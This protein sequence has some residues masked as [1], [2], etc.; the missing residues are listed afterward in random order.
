MILP[1]KVEGK[2]FIVTLLICLFASLVTS[3]YIL[4]TEQNRLVAET[5]ERLET[6][7]MR[8]VGHIM[9][10]LK[11]REN[12][13]K[14]AAKSIEAA[15]TS[16]PDQQ[17]FSLRSNPDGSITGIS[18]TLASSYYLPAGTELT[19]DLNS[20]ILGTQKAID[21]LAP[22][23]LS[24]FSKVTLITTDNIII[25]APPSL[26]P[27]GFDPES[28]PLMREA[29]TQYQSFWT[30]VRYD[31]DSRTWLTSLVVPLRHAGRYL[32]MLRC[33][34]KLDRIFS[35]IGSLAGIEG[36]SAFI[37]Q[38]TDT[39]LAHN[40]IASLIQ[41]NKGV[42]NDISASDIN[43]PN[44]H[45]IVQIYN[46]SLNHNTKSTQA[47]PVFTY[48]HD[49][50]EYYAF[51]HATALSAW[52]WKL[53]VYTD[54]S[55]I[56]TYV[57][58]LAW[59]SLFSSMALAF[60]FML[61][62]RD[63]FRRLFLKRIIALEKATHDYADTEEFI[64]PNSGKD[65]IGQLAFSF[66]NLIH[67]L[68]AGKVRLTEQAL[69]L[70]SEILERQT[71]VESLEESEDKFEALFEN[72]PDAIMLLDDKTCIDCNLAAVDLLEFPDKSQLLQNTIADSSPTFQPDGQASAEK[73]ETLVKHAH[74]YGKYNFE[75]VIKTVSDETIWVDVLLT[76]IPYQ[77]TKILYA[78]MRNISDRKREEVERVRLT[79]AIEQAAESIMVTD[80]SG[81]ILYVNPAFQELNQY[82]REEIIGKN[83]EILYGDNPKSV[84]I[85]DILSSVFR[86]IIWKGRLTYRRNDQ[87]EYQA[88]STISPVRDTGG[89]IMNFVYVS[90]DVTKEASLET[91]LRQAQKMEAIGELASGIAHEINTPTQYIG[92][93]IRFFRD[94]FQDITD[95]LNKFKKL[96]ANSENGSTL[97]KDRADI[98]KLIDDIDLEF[99]EEEI[100]TAIEQ[101]LDGNKRVAEIVRAMKEFAHPGTEERSA[102]DVNHAIRNTMSVARNEWKYVAEIETDLAEDLPLVPC[103]PGS[104]NQVILNL[105]VNAA[106]AIGDV[107]KDGSGGKGTIKVST[108]DD[109]GWVE[110]RISDTGCGIPESNRTKIFD[111]FF[112]TKE[113]GKGTGQG[114]SIAHSVIVEK[115]N[116][117]I[118][119]ESV[120]GEGTTFIIR[121]PLTFE[122]ES[123]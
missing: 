97:E 1:E 59:K 46:E 16:V 54:R 108:R 21:I 3:R 112:T 93:N 98:R 83:A 31:S 30:P 5:K 123:P 116:G 86:G 44:L 9:G 74:T 114:L 99:L 107:V 28:H 115:H 8:H 90:R 66:Q 91:Q 64:I 2:L 40:M 25:S 92:D 13:G 88:D 122:T 7:G 4:S 53:A 12:E 23:L 119:F 42:Y 10:Q 15:I 52:D 33:D 73:W 111:P 32:G 106:H 105:I 84:S 29:T 20:K 17:Q 104:F 68:E 18:P 27:T 71:A 82:K 94:S 51:V 87:T 70:E 75:W 19:L 80:T 113:V 109:D 96:L 35:D 34:F 26:I 49:D 118:D 50:M 77:G 78:V 41:K 63:V 65:E 57:A 37:I 39:I 14:Q 38:D 43:D 24:D 72:S 67:S 47:N 56:D 89:N 103:Y 120:V 61:V 79:T 76:A 121:V 55:R 85:R 45:Q 48:S 95:L 117:T 101:S 69:Q 102:I 6:V 22:S 62:I 100:P 11:D 60:I 81:V 110:I 36:G 58:S